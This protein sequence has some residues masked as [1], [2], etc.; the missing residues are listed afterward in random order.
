MVSR[1]VVQWDRDVVIAADAVSGRP[2]GISSSVAIDLSDG[3]F[4]P[5]EI[6]EKLKQGLA[7]K[8]ISAES[9]VAVLSRE[10]VTFHRLTLPNLSEDELPEIVRLQAATRLTAPVES[11]CLDFV[12][13]PEVPGMETRDVLL[14]TAPASHVNELRKALSQCGL[15]LSGLRVSSFGIADAVAASGLLS[16]TATGN[17]VEVIVSL[18]ADAIEI[19]FT[20]GG[21]VLFSHS[22]ASWTS[23]ENVEQAVRATVSRAR[24]AA[25]EDI[26]EYT[27]SRL[28]LIGDE[29]ATAVVPDS[30]SKR[31]NDAPVERIQPEGTLFSGPVPQG[32]SGADL[33]PLVGAAAAE[34]QTS[35]PSVDL[36]NPRKP[37]PK[38]DYSRL[39]KLA[40]GG[41]VA[42]LV[43]GL[44]SWRA[45]KI[46]S[47][48]SE[49]ARI[50]GDISD[51]KDELKL[52]KNDLQ[53]NTR[54]TEWMD[55]DIHWTAELLTI[56]RLMEDTER[57][58]MKSF[59]GSIAG[60]GSE[61][62]RITIEGYAKDR[63][64]IEDFARVLNEAGYDVAPTE[65][66]L[67]PRDP[68]YRYEM[69]LEVF[70]P[71]ARGKSEKTS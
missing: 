22:G 55:R 62:G 32:L 48:E 66:P 4:T 46:K 12:P 3:N 23:D 24:M 29:Q 9:C 2:A 19:V 42:L 52:G 21:N 43:V 20:R 45:N 26:G 58:Y 61:L 11:V 69:N 17:N 54:L 31:L 53:L 25:A 7:E 41:S 15:Q 51:I 40:V 27:V 30:I 60:R 5:D 38:T 49:T 47:Y 1:L 6:G 28:L 35:G 59:K 65:M 71:A 64:D 13:L 63:R 10:L 44:W 70:I 18:G 57:I 67:N 68:A 14:V 50:K 34:S 56:R 33:L 36:I 16:S 8:S 39:I 37:V